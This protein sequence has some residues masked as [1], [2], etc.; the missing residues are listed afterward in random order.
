LSALDPGHATA[1]HSR[2]QLA[3]AGRHRQLPAAPMQATQPDTAQLR[4]RSAI[5]NVTGKTC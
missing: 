5:Q 4:I 1:L 2:L 3:A